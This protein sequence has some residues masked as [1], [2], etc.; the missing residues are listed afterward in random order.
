MQILQDYIGSPAGGLSNVEPPK[1]W[2]DYGWVSSGPSDNNDRVLYNR[3]IDKDIVITAGKTH[4]YP[5]GRIFS[6]NVKGAFEPGV[7]ENIADDKYPI[8][9]MLCGSRSN[10]FDVIN[11]NYK[12]DPAT[13]RAL[14]IPFKEAFNAPFVSFHAGYIFETSEYNNATAMALTIGTAVTATYDLTG[15]SDIGGMVVPAIRYLN[16]VIGIIVTQSAPRNPG[17][18]VNTIEIQ[19][20][21]LPKLSKTIATQILA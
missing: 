13:T 8:V 21:V 14:Y 18:D 6:M 12:S 1:M 7:D 4:Y 19:S 3:P 9:A 15:D 20:N 17:S 2:D 5:K 16:N 10:D 11:S